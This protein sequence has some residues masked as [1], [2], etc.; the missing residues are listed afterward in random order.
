VLTERMKTQRPNN[1]QPGRWSTPE[2]AS[3]CEAS[4]T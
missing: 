2:G 4:Q 1:L 3:A